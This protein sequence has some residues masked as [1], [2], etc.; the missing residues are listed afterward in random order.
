MSDTLTALLSTLPPGIPDSIV[1]IFFGDANMQIIQNGIHDAI[2]TQGFLID[3][4]DKKALTLLMKNTLG[5]NANSS[6]DI[7]DLNSQV[8][9]EAV[10]IISS[11]IQ[12]NQLLLA[13]FD[14]SPVPLDR[15]INTNIRGT[16]LG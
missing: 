2:L 12:R 1:T 3:P 16:R 6:F 11:A 7:A 10:R 8:V 9:I 4:Q 13:R 5:K 15:G 14:K